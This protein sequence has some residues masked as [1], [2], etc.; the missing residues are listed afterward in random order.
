MKKIG[1]GLITESVKERIRELIHRDFRSTDAGAYHF[2][3][4][5]NRDVLAP[6]MA[7]IKD[8]KT[9]L[10]LDFAA[11]VIINASSVHVAARSY[12]GGYYQNRIQK[13]YISL[14]DDQSTRT[15]IEAY[16]QHIL[17][18][19]QEAIKNFEREH[20]RNDEE[21]ALVA[22]EEQAKLVDD[23]KE[24]LGSNEKWAGAITNP[25]Q[26]IKNNPQILV[27]SREF[28]QFLKETRPELSRLDREKY[29]LLAAVVFL[30]MKNFDTKHFDILAN[31]IEDHLEPK[32][33][34]EENQISSA[35]YTKTFIGR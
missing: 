12:F 15:I 26:R 5:V 4:D 1:E 2:D 7:Q 13:E 30:S 18:K 16:A 31:L 22:R 14:S 33:I 28:D 24:I 27:K 32:R 35:Q 9:E 19:R 10:E 3:I 34:I 17:T 23:V 21:T 29:H 20:A 6:L 8:K 25:N 11:G